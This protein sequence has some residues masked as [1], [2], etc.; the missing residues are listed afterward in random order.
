MYAGF[1]NKETDAIAYS[2]AG[3]D[4]NYIFTIT[5]D[6]SIYLIKSKEIFSYSKLNE[7]MEEFF[8]EFNPMI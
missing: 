2:A 7:L 3:V 1:G 8:P 4:I 6:G 5:P